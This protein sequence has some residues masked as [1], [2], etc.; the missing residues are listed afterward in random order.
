MFFFCFFFPV[1][2]ATGDTWVTFSI[3]L[4]KEESLPTKFKLLYSCDWGIFDSFTLHVISVSWVSKQLD[5]SIYNYISVYSVT[6][7]LWFWI[8]E[9]VPGFLT[10]LLWTPPPQGC[11]QT[12]LPLPLPPYLGLLHLVVPQTPPMP[13]SPARWRLRRWSLPPLALA[14]PKCCMTMMLQIQVNFPFLLMR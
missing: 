2:S 13:L 4:K 10:L 12:L 3:T 5:I 8:C 1:P 11:Q 6:L 7:C 14:R 9:S